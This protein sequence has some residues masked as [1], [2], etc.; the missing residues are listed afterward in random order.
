MLSEKWLIL[1]CLHVSLTIKLSIGFDQSDISTPGKRHPS[2]AEDEVIAL[3]LQLLYVMVCCL[4]HIPLV[5]F[6][7]PIFFVLAVTGS[8][9]TG[10]TFV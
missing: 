1:L 7:V 8:G 10:V 9:A 4:V 5:I 2:M 6:P 3:L